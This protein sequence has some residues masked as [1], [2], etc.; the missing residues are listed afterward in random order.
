[1]DNLSDQ[2][3]FVFHIPS[4]YNEDDSTDTEVRSG[5]DTETPS[6]DSSVTD[7]E[8]TGMYQHTATD[9]RGG[10]RNLI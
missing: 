9:N 7:S 10:S 1:M 3:E 8:S 6:V 2:E 5:H 4:I